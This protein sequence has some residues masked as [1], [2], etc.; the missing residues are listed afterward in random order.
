MVTFSEESSSGCYPQS[1]AIAQP[2][3]SRFPYR[4]QPFRLLPIS[5]INDTQAITIFNDHA[6]HLARHDIPC[7]FIDRERLLRVRTLREKP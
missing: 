5:L 1:R 2:G 7:N 6:G 4:I 3:L